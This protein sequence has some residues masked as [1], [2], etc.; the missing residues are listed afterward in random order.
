MAG[1]A[2]ELGFDRAGSVL[3][4]AGG[5]YDASYVL[6]NGWAFV[7]GGLCYAATVTLLWA[8]GIFLLLV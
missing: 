2:S 7:F 3:D 8:S 6:S 4:V 1:R 5:L